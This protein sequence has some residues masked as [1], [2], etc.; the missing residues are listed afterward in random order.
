MGELMG[1]GLYPHIRDKNPLVRFENYNL[2]G[3]WSPNG[4]LLP[5]NGF[6]F[7]CRPAPPPPSQESKCNSNTG[8]RIVSVLTGSAA[9][10]LTHTEAQ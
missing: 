3:E 4:L 9:Q 6:N 10:H 5:V 1:G 2:W 8:C 7:F